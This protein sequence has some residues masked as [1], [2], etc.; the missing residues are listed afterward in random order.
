MGMMFEQDQAG[1]KPD[2]QDLIAVVNSDEAPFTSMLPKIKRPLQVNQMW[3]GKKYGN[4]GHKGVLDGKDADTFVSTNR[5]EIQGRAQKAWN[6]PAVSDFATEAE[7]AGLSKGEMAE[8]IA[9]S[10][11]NLKL[12]IEKRALSN[13]ECQIENGTVPNETRGMGKWISAT[14]QSVYPVPVDMRT[15]AAAILSGALSTVTE[16]TFKTMMRAMFKVRKAPKALHGFVGIELKAVISDWGTYTTSTS[17]TIANTRAQN[18]DAEKKTLMNVIDKLVL[19]T[20]DVFLHPTAY[21][22]T[23]AADGEDSA[24]THRSGIF[25]DMDYVGLGYNRA[26]NVRKLEDKGGG[27]K[28][29]VDAIF[30]L[31]NRNPSGMAKIESNA[32]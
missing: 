13:E 16:S 30:M 5:G 29:I 14:A 17:S 15:P 25:L 10:M 8:Q 26:P 31:V 7:V 12:I 18:I 27:Q 24:Y 23:T 19:D 11:V 22:Y 3:Q 9:T 6:N 2:I 28:A 32:A 1:K 20:G 4:V 21:L